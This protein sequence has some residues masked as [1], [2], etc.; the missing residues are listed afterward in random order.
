MTPET[1]QSALARRLVM[2]RS[3]VLR[4]QWPITLAHAL[5]AWALWRDGLETA[6]AAWFVVMT[7]VNL[8]RSW[9]LPRLSAVTE[10]EAQ[11]VSRIAF[12]WLVVIGLLRPVPVLLTLLGHD[13]Q[14][15][16]LIT[17]IMLGLTVGGAPNLAGLMHLYD[18]WAAPLFLAFGGVWLARADVEGVAIALLLAMF[19]VVLRSYVRDYGAVLAREMTWAEQLRVERDRAEEAIVARG[20]FFAAASHDLRQPVA[21]MRWYGEA[22]EEHARLLGHEGLKQIGEGIARAMARADPLLAQYLEIS[23]LEAREAPLP[24]STVDLGELLRQTADA[25]APQARQQG[26]SIRVESPEALGLGDE[27]TLRRIL[28]NLVANAIKFTPAGAVTLAVEAATPGRWRVSVSD[29]GVGIA[30]ADQSHVFDDFFQIGNAARASEK[31]VGLGLSIARRHAERLGSALRLS[32]MPGQGSR[33]EF[34]LSGADDRPALAAAPVHVQQD[35]LPAELNFLVVDDDAEVRQ[36]LRAR[37]EARGWIAHTASTMDEALA[38]WR[39]GVVPDIV[40]ADH[41]LGDDRTGAE[42]IAALRAEGCE[43]PAIIITGDTAPDRLAQLSR[44][45]LAVLHKPVSD[46]LLVQAVGQLLAV[47]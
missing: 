6:A 3:Q 23:R 27:P 14:G 24:L 8:A 20:R 17:M 35:D 36:A 18:V 9:Q 4:A 16:Y 10:E 1:A 47:A 31:G 42:L 22:V 34:E 37:L 45:G 25:W 15:L 5:V 2:A 11:R 13:A 32:S 26:L 39:G 41:R 12:N 33:F 40:L 7:G 46:R 30:P 44:S 43:A 21:A 28:D 19:F 29:T 38:Q